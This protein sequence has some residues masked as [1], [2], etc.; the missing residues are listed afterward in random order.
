VEIWS[1]GCLPLAGF[2]PILQELEQR[3]ELLFL[4][5]KGFCFGMNFDDCFSN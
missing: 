2:V 4:Y 5:F 3:T 1:S